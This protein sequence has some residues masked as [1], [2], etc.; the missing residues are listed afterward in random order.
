MKIFAAVDGPNRKPVNEELEKEK[1][2][3]SERVLGSHLVPKTQR[4]LR[5]LAFYLVYAVDRAD[6]AIS[7]ADIVTLYSEEFE[8][9]VEA[10]SLAVE[11]AHGAITQRDEFDEIVRP[12]LKNWKLERLG[13]CTR[14]IIRIAL[15]ELLVVKTPTSVVINEAV[16]LAK[17]FAEKDAYK[18]VNGILD[19]VARIN[20]I[21]ENSPR[22]NSVSEAE[23]QL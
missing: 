23:E 11:L 9:F 7:L 22:E 14:I 6:Y 13:V 8:V 16:E 10:N 2:I 3:S 12:L 1:E 20:G 4:D 18:F 15:F 19:E 17:A 21:K 5:T